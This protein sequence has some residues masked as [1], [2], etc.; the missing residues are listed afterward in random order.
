MKKIERIIPAAKVNMDGHL[1]D[2][3]LPIDNLEQHDPFLL[4]HHWNNPLH[5]SS[6]QNEVGVGPH[7]HRGFSPV[8]FIF[9]GAVQHRDSRGNNSVVEAGGTQWMNAGMGITHSERPTKELAEKGGEFEIIQFWVNSPASMKMLQPEYQA[10]SKQETPVYNT[11]DQLAKC[12]V[13]CGNQFGLT[14]PIKHNW[15]ILA[16]RLEMLKGG[17]L[18]MDIP[19]GFNTLLYNLDGNLTVNKKDRSF[20]KDMVIFEQS[21][22]KIH[23]KADGNT[24]AIILAGA[25]IGENI[26]KYG[27]F[28][29]NTESEILQALRDSQMGKMG[30]LIEE[31]D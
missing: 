21:H 7:P 11:K 8:T 15:P 2:Q 10:L 17:E 1:L 23:I 16:L 18:E 24:R 29:M 4:I 27:P 26:S 22:N 31:F 25:P 9:S 3:P 6:R 28:V 19:N 30:I 5:G 12:A 20:M 14:G 13:V